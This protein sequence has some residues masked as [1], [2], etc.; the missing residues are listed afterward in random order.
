MN[1]LDDLLDHLPDGSS[2]DWLII[3]TWVLSTLMCWAGWEGIFWLIMH[4]SIGLK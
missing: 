2:P 3:F 4:V 1:L